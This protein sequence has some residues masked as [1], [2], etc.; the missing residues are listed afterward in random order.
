MRYFLGESFR[1]V[2]AEKVAEISSDEYYINMM[3]AWFFAT[4]LAKQYESA[5]KLFEKQTLDA[6]THTKS[7]QKA[8]ESFRVS[9]EHKAYLNTL[10]VKPSYRQRLF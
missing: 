9:E 5:V 3:R 2:Y 6:F 1:T 4:A 10:K 8:R 7:I